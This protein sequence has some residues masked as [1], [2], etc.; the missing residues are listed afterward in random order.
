MKILKIKVA[1]YPDHPMGYGL[2]YPP[3]DELILEKIM[4]KLQPEEKLIR[5]FIKEKYKIN[6]D[7]QPYIPPGTE[8]KIPRGTL[9]LYVKVFIQ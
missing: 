6:P 4:K 5:Y 9:T 8:L 7:L 3:S 2:M 1:E